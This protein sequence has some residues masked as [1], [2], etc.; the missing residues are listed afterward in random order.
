MQNQNHSDCER[1]LMENSHFETTDNPQCEN[2]QRFESFSIRQQQ[3]TNVKTRR[4]LQ[5]NEKLSIK[6]LQNRNHIYG[7]R[8][9]DEFNDEIPQTITTTKCNTKFL[10][11]H[12]HL[13]QYS[14]EDHQGNHLCQNLH[15]ISESCQRFRIDNTRSV[16]QTNSTPVENVRLLQKNQNQNQVEQKRHNNPANII[17]I[18]HRNHALQNRPSFDYKRPLQR[19]R[20]DSFESDESMVV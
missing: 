4:T 15:E 18:E 11:D 8:F 19:C 9:S 2:Q 12:L 1:Q 20:S 14:F 13:S 17:R 5:D 16:C 7:R 3:I 6:V 10:P